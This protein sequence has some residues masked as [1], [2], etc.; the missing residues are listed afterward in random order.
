MT[1]F[2]PCALSFAATWEPG[3][4]NGI[5]F[6]VQA[7]LGRGDLSGARAVVSRASA[8]LDPRTVGVH[9]ATYYELHWALDSAQQALLVGSRPDDFNDDTG[10]WG[11]AHAN[12]YTAWGDRARARAY[13]DSARAAFSEQLRAAP[14]DA[15]TVGLLALA[16][17]LRGS[18]DEA[19]RQGERATQ[20]AHRPHYAPIRTHPAFVRLL[21][22]GS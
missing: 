16:L 9:L 19:I 3:N 8:E 13:A 10:S 20:A 7:R 12:I 1:R 22:G 11:L 2:V 6:R 21:A 4:L 15:P 14:D 18:T 5:L 17:A